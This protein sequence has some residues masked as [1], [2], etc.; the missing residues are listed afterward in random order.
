MT[1]RIEMG[2]K[3]RH[4]IIERLLH[5]LSPRAWKRDRPS[6]RVGVSRRFDGAPDSLRLFRDALYL[7][8]TELVPNMR[9]FTSMERI[10]HERT[11]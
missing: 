4:A 11:E 9:Y 1:N 7:G 2:L 10:Y 8:L 5:T 6:I 3:G